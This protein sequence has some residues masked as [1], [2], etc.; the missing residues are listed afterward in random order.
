MTSDSLEARLRSRSE[1]APV[2]CQLPDIPYKGAR[3]VLE[4]A[5]YQLAVEISPADGGRA[6]LGFGT[7]SPKIWRWFPGPNDR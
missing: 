5:A 1:M 7:I 6:V 3:Y 4:N 2:S